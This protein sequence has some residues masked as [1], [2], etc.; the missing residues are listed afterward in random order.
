MASHECTC[1][2]PQ[3]C[4]TE[5]PQKVGQVTESMINLEEW[6]WGFSS[7]LVCLLWASSAKGDAE[8]QHWLKERILSLAGVSDREGC[9]SQRS[10]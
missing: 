3:V 5:R 6:Q 8:A 1:P 7:F 9:P 2:L 10:I 4:H